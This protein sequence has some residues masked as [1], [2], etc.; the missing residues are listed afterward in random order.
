MGSTT[1]TDQTTHSSSHENGQALK[2][3]QNRE[4]EEKFGMIKARSES[5]LSRGHHL[6]DGNEREREK[7]REQLR[8]QR[9]NK[10]IQFLSTHQNKPS[11][12]SNRDSIDN[13]EFDLSQYG[14]A[15]LTKEQVEQMCQ[16][17]MNAPPMI[18]SAITSVRLTNNQLDARDIQQLTAVLSSLPRLSHLYLGLN[19]VNNQGLKYVLELFQAQPAVANR[20]MYLG[21][22]GN[23]ID[24][25]GGEELLRFL[26]MHRYT[27]HIFVDSNRIHY[28][29]QNMIYVQQRV[30]C[31]W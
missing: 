22:H 12:H 7:E 20:L 31:W 6:E 24:E 16:A 5:N 28:H 10:A 18:R 2:Q 25:E 9:F 26:Q 13:V 17:M 3:G 27:T 1:S 29:L 14:A 4:R 30:C 19:Q 15:P 11:N 21:L 8:D 23:D